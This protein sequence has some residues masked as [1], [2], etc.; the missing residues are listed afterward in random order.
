MFHSSSS[1][2][3]PRYCGVPVSLFVPKKFHSFHYLKNTHFYFIPSFYFSSS[4][5]S[6]HNNNDAVS[7]FYRLLRQNPTPPDIEFGKILGSL[8]KSKHYHTVLSLS[9]KMEFKGIKLN[10]LNCNILINSFCQLG[11]IPFAFSVL[12]R[13]V[14]WIEILK[15][16]F[17]RKN[18][19]DF[20]RLC[21]IVLILWDFKR[22]FLKDFL[23]SR[24]FARF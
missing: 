10:F 9:Q 24:L 14:Y 23:Q 7:L 2:M 18:L 12:T 6:S 13:G 11:L 19:E 3:L 17:D 1:L 21:W 15:D 4:S 20:K 22:L 5:I 8:V 16:C